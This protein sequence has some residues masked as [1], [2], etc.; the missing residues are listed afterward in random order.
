VDV[1]KAWLEERNGERRRCF[2]LALRDGS[3]LDVSRPESG[4]LWTIDRERDE[5]RAL[6]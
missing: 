6:P 4:G 3:V 1:I 2:R 5:P